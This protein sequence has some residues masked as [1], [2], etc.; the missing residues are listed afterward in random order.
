MSANMRRR[1]NLVDIDCKRKLERILLQLQRYIKKIGGRKSHVEDLLMVEL[2]H[3]ML[4]ELL[5]LEDSNK[6]TSRS[7]RS[8]IFNRSLLL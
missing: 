2:L 4:N 1:L 7:C 5:T 8:Q 3:F 6:H